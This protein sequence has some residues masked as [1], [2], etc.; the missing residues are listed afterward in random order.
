LAL[1][2]AVIVLI[3]IFTDTFP[4][5]FLRDQARAIF[6][7]VR[8]NG[9]TAAVL[10]LY[11]EESGVPMPV[12][13]DAFV[14][15]LGHR[16]SSGWVPGILVCLTITAAVVLGASNL[17]VISRRWGRRIVEG[18][19]GRVF[20]ITPRRIERAERWFAR[21][22]PFALIFGR[23]IPGFRVPITVAAGTL[24]VSYRTFA[25]CVGVSTITWS[26]FFLAVGHMLGDRVGIFIQ[27][28]RQ[29]TLVTV[30]AVIVA[31]VVYVVF[32]LLQLRGVDLSLRPQDHGEEPRPP[33]S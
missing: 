19:T 11:L 13:G 26:A 2:L 20:H 30:A 27:V 31:A 17:Y 3:S 10:L 15:F 7:F 24:G 5:E 25:L 29:T 14:M 6:A 18:K 16:L 8:H 21:W 32:R 9:G 1:L 22:G 33:R 28:H 4:D 12:P 23:H